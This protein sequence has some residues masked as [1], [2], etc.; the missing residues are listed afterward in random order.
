MP[1]RHLASDAWLGLLFNT[2]MQVE[3]EMLIERAVDVIV[4]SMFVMLLLVFSPS[5]IIG[6]FEKRF[7]ATRKTDPPTAPTAEVKVA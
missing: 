5:G 3:L 1:P 7:T 6:F 4:A 2:R